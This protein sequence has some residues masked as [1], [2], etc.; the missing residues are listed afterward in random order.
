IEEL[1]ASSMQH[2]RV[3]V[4]NLAYEVASQDLADHMGQVGTVLV[5]DVLKLAGGRSKGCGIV[6]YADPAS[7]E[8]AIHELCN[9]ELFN[10]QIFVR[11]DREQE[12]KYGS[13]RTD[14][15][16]SSGG[17]EPSSH[18]LFV[19]NLAF[20]VTWTMLKDW[21]REANAGEVAHA[22][23]RTDDAG[24]S[25]GHGILIYNSAEDAARAAE[26]LNGTMLQGRPAEVRIDR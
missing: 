18:Q 22:T 4:G 9:T 20:S 8:R 23:V 19:G 26:A 24:H 13:N 7:A 12:A 21:A 6:E 11:E 1:R 16:G 10:R 5:A 15:R 3:Y 2:R 14:A 25:K 17:S